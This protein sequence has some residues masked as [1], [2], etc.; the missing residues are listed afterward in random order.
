MPTLVELLK[1]RGAEE[2]VYVMFVEYFLSCVVGKRDQSNKM[3]TKPVYVFAD[4]TDEAY[5]MLL[6][7]NYY[8]NWME[9]ARLSSAEQKTTKLSQLPGHHPYYRKATTGEVGKSWSEAAFAV[10]DHYFDFV[11]TNRKAF[12][13]V[14]DKYMRDLVNGNRTSVLRCSTKKRKA[15]AAAPAVQKTTVAPKSTFVLGKNQPVLSVVSDSGGDSS[16]GSSGGVNSAEEGS[17]T[18]DQSSSAVYEV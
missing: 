18:V 13:E 16:S 6:L 17:G 11:Q 9:H 3:L 8:E 5:T 7:S 4:V 10:Y 15:V 2:D 12:Q 14:D 1:L